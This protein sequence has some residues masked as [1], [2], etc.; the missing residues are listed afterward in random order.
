MSGVDEVMED[1]DLPE[2]MDNNEA[3]VDEAPEP[4]VAVDMSALDDAARLRVIEAMIFMADAPV[5]MDKLQQKLGTDVDVPMLIVQLQESYVGRGIDLVS[6]AGGYA[7]R[8]AL[9][10]NAVLKGEKAVEVRKPPRAATETL[11]IVAYH[12]PVTRAEI[13]AIRGVQVSRGTLDLLMEAGWVRPGKR[14]ETPGR[15]VTWLTTPQFL[16]HFGLSSLRD[17]PGLEELKAAGMLD[18]K[19]VL[20]TM[21]VEPGFEE[22]LKGLEAEDDNDFLPA[23]DEADDYNAPRIAERAID[24]ED[25][26]EDDD[27]ADDE[28]DGDEDQDD[29]SSDDADSDGEDE[30]EEEPEEDDS[31]DDDYDDE[32]DDDDD[33][34][35]EDED[36]NAADANPRIVAAAE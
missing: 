23:G 25:S 35:E 24:G 20:A 15:P 31:D 3:P 19:P 12:Q 33:L 17:L 16:E 8:T 4:I 5:S 6:V 34:D 29:D 18:A 28:G 21:P 36:E 14:R 27:L 32:D 13:E 1:A 2:D 10:L 26:D 7:F 9:D 22:G 30:P 11:A